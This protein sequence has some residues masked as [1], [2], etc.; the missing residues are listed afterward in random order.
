MQRLA[1]VTGAAS[2]IGRAISERLVADGMRVLA[3]DVAADGL[4]SL[5]AAHGDAVVTAHCDVTSEA[6]L[7]SVAALGAELGGF[8]VVV[9]NAGRGAF[10]PIVGHPLDEWKAIIDLCLTGVFLT[11]KHGARVMNEG[12]SIIKIGRAHV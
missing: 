8:D 11:I 5:A 9:A 3:T 4:A 1:L 12:G 2:G 10:A 7:E 6:D